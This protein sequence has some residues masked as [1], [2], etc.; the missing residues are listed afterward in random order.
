MK[1]IM[2]LLLIFF[3]GTKFC[4]A[5][6]IS[7]DDKLH[8]GTGALISA[9]TYGLVYSVSKNKKKAF[10]YSLGTSTLAGLAKEIY[11]SN[12]ENNEFDTGEMIATS[13]GGLTA[14]V[15]INLFVGNRKN[16]HVSFVPI[17]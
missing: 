10:W 7:G 17:E 16:K 1:P 8:F 5:Q 3:A 11:D 14:T 12:Q 2:V 4:N 6:F 9:A 13:L 15:T